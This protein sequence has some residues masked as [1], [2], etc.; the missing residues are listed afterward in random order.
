[1]RAFTFEFKEFLNINFEIKR[2]V[3][4]EIVDS[5]LPEFSNTLPYP[6]SQIR[7]LTTLLCCKINAALIEKTRNK[8]L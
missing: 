1:M 6:A 8:L 7:T 4:I 2:K 3:V 5:K